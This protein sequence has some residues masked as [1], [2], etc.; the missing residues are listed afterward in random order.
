MPSPWT[1]ILKD[2]VVPGITGVVGYVGRFLQTESRK[3]RMR[4][5]LYREISRNNQQIVL[6]IA[7]ATST[8]GFAMGLPLCFANGLDVS[9]LVWNFYHD[10]EQRALLFELKEADAIS[11]IY[12]KVS[13]IEN[14]ATDSAWQLMRAK[15]ASAEVDE[16]LLD[17]SLNR[18]IYRHVSTKEACHG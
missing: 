2:V 7:V 16:R 1:D 6:R 9:F 4:G 15:E 18:G 12:A 3:R 14:E 5:Q 13:N 8:R 17:G 11:R 10:G